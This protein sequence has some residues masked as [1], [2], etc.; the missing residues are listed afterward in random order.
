MPLAL[1]RQKLIAVIEIGGRFLFTKEQ[2]IAS[3]GA[4]HLA[5]LK[6]GAKRRNTGTRA[7][8]D[9]RRVVVFGQEKMLRRLG[10]D[11]RTALPKAI[12]QVGRA[13]AF[14]L[15]IADRGHRQMHLAWV[16]AGA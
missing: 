12:G 7:D 3:A 4:L 2:P 16:E 6:K 1:P 11:S 5:L 10:E 15:A 13:H 14:A 8:H 9:D